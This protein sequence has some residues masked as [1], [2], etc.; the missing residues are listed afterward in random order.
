MSVTDTTHQMWAGY[1]L[2]QTDSSHQAATKPKWDFTLLST[3]RSNMRIRWKPKMPSNNKCSRDR[4]EEQETKTTIWL[5]LRLWE[6]KVAL[7]FKEDQTARTAVV[8]VASHSNTT[9]TRTTMAIARKKTRI[10]RRTYMIETWGKAEKS[11]RRRTLTSHL[12][13][14][15][16]PLLPILLLMFLPLSHHHLNN[17]IAAIMEPQTIRYHNSKTYLPTS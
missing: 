4:E 13:L 1:Q 8:W 7:A 11:S 10:L 2:T 17:K 9:I 3:M 12:I 16:N 6:D 5:T 15:L 14:P